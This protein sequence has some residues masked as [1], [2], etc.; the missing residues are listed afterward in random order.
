MPEPQAAT[1]RPPASPFRP[2][3]VGADQ[4]DWLA[5]L[6]RE[7][8]RQ[9][10]ATP[11]ELDALDPEEAA[12]L[13]EWQ[14]DFRDR[15]ASYPEPATDWNEAERHDF[16][17]ALFDTHATLDEGA[18]ERLADL[19]TYIPGDDR[20]RSFGQRIEELVQE[21]GTPR[22]ETIEEFKAANRD[23]FRGELARFYQRAAEDWAEGRSEEHPV[24]R[25]N[26]WI[27]AQADRAAAA[28]T[29]AT[30]GE[31]LDRSML[32]PR[33]VLTGLGEQVRGAVELRNPLGPGG[34]LRGVPSMDRDRV[35]VPRPVARF[36]ERF[37]ADMDTA[38]PPA[39]FFPQVDAAGNVRQAEPFT[40]VAEFGGALA[41]ELAL[42]AATEGTLR[43]VPKLAGAARSRAAAVGINAGRGGLPVVA[44]EVGV[45]RRLAEQLRPDA[46]RQRGAAGAIA[47][48]IIEDVPTVAVAGAAGRGL[49]SEEF[50]GSD[51]AL[52]LR[53]LAFDVASAGLEAGFARAADELAPALAST[54]FA[55]PTPGQIAEVRQRFGSALH[56]LPDDHPVHAGLRR[57]AQQ[58]IADR[59]AAARA[60]IASASAGYVTGFAL[61]QARGGSMEDAI[62]AGAFFS[63]IAQ[64]HHEPRTASELLDD[65]D[66]ARRMVVEAGEP[67]LPGRFP[68]R[69]V[70]SG[71]EAALADAYD[72]AL[73]DAFPILELHRRPK[74][75]DS[76][77]AWEFARRRAEMRER[78]SLFQ[79]T[80]VPRESVEEG[81]RRLR[82]EFG[83][84]SDLPE[85]PRRAV[86]VDFDQLARAAAPAPEVAEAFARFQRE[87]AEGKLGRPPRNEAEQ[88]SA[89]IGV[90]IDK[91]K[92]GTA[93]PEELAFLRARGIDPDPRR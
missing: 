68:G 38:E 71:R 86:A 16:R 91:A 70:R 36:A 50:I 2:L 78:A 56:H 35:D 62:L 52:D 47:A 60:R 10:A 41:G 44:R 75:P 33:N 82:Q 48:S 15:L 76:P 65:L 8:G 5:R 20:A 3:P 46:L 53:E 25:A 43:A 92:A 21:D 63:V 67:H 30:E 73:A 72:Q 11:S 93:A 14:A 34:V 24:A 61:E 26:R 64:R 7:L 69:P 49:R 77:D 51:S 17:R 22:P 40:A 81:F 32:D 58:A 9:L 80:Q 6:N 45:G 55:N 54:S 37:G 84:P 29:R 85:A 39:S 19:A 74:L 90:L 66:A 42:F 27:H 28:H 12:A 13:R 57:I 59:P 18:A 31:F 23:H 83:L 1:P 89:F 79:N 4:G 88:T 87:V